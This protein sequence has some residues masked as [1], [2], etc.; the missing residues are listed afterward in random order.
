[1]LQRNYPHLLQLAVLEVVV[2]APNGSL[3]SIQH[4]VESLVHGGALLFVLALRNSVEAEE[5]T[6]DGDA[7]LNVGLFGLLT[8]GF[9]SVFAVD[10]TPRGSGEAS[11]FEPCSGCKRE[12]QP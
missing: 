1:M 10:T 7:S 3:L 2:V 4:E 12:E 8:Y 9:T 11:V 5:R 6:C